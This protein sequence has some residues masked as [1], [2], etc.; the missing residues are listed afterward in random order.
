MMHH[1][2]QAFYDRGD[3]T[4][5]GLRKPQIRRLAKAGYDSLQQQAQALLS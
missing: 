5:I 2:Q 4:W 1:V 3:R